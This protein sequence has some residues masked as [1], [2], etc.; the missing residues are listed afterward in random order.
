MPL[1]VALFVRALTSRGLSQREFARRVGLSPGSIS[2]AIS[3]M[4]V[5]DWR[6]GPVWA[7][8]LELTGEDRRRFLEA[9]DLANSPPSVQRLVARLRRHP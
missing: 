2:K 3:G 6:R 4:H 7:D 1:F 8:V 9:L 5:P